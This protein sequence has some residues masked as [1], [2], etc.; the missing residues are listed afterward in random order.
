M[1]AV[2]ENQQPSRPGSS[3][4]T[5]STSSATTPESIDKSKEF[6][7]T[8]RTGRRNALPNILSDEMLDNSDLPKQFEALSTTDSKH[9]KAKDEPG[10]S[11]KSS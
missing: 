9:N 7:A 5:D 4:I 11:K 3:R 1:L 10:P 2:M 8:T 6:Q